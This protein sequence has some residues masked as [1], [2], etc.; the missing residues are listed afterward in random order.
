MSQNAIEGIEGG[1]T[2]FVGRKAVAVFQ[3]TVVASGLRMYARTGMKPSR[4]WT[5]AAMMAKASELTGKVFKGRDYIAAAEALEKA[6]KEMAGE[7]HQ[8]NAQATI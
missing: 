2:A 4:Q 8:D 7:I 5:P 1:G 3:Y 6:A